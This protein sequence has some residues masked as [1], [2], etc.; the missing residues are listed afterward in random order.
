MIE[1]EICSFDCLGQF[2]WSS[3]TSDVYK[4]QGYFGLWHWNHKAKLHRCYSM[5]YCCWKCGI[6]YSVPSITCIYRELGSS[7]RYYGISFTSRRGNLSFG[8]TSWY[9]IWYIIWQKVY[10][11]SAVEFVMHFNKIIASGNMLQPTPYQATFI[12][13]ICSAAVLNEATNWT[14][15]VN[16]RPQSTVKWLKCKSGI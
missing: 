12:L 10:D 2:L 9:I 4:L 13:T 1:L 16:R 8:C 7:Q 15:A 6:S 11:A 3:L 5:D 14:I